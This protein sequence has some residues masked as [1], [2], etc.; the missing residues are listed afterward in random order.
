MNK[1][2]HPL[3]ETLVMIGSFILLWAW[4]LQRVSTRL[5]QSASVGTTWTV[6]QLLSITALI[7]VFVRRMSRVRRAMKEVE[8]TFGFTSP[9]KNKKK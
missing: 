8:K 2:S 4:L 1:S 9:N 5:P 6:I 3:W 7:W